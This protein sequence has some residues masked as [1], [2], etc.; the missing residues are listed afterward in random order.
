[1]I[2]LYLVILV[3]FT[4]ILLLFPVAVVMQ[5]IAEF[6]TDAPFVPVPKEIEND[7][8]ISL[9]LVPNSILYDLGCGDARILLK[10]VQKHSD[11]KAVG[12][13]IGFLPYFLAKFYTRKHKNIKIKRGDIFKTNISDATHIFI[14][15]SP[16]INKLFLHICQQCKPD[17]RIVSCD[18]ELENTTPTQI[19]ELNKT[20]SPRGKKL[21]V[22]TL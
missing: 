3:L 5:F 11:I 16:A 20:T 8:I 17:T 12:I 15:L 22:Y 14:Y 21:F 19:I 2:L 18:F 13:D 1:M 10:A 9:K 4:I 7:I 6:T